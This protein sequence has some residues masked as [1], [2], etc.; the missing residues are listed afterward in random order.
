MVA[1]SLFVYAGKVGKYTN[2]C[3]C[4]ELVEPKTA[5][6][7]SESDGDRLC[8]RLATMLEKL[9]D[10]QQP[11]YLSSPIQSQNTVANSNLQASIP[12]TAANVSI[13]SN[14]NQATGTSKQ[15]PS[16]NCTE[17]SDFFDLC[18]SNENNDAEIVPTDVCEVLI[19]RIYEKQ[20]DGR[21]H[22]LVMFGEE[23]L[24]SLVD[25]GS[26]C[27]L[28]G[29]NHYENSEYLKSLPL[30]D[31]NIHFRT[32]D[33]KRH[34]CAGKL[35]VDFTAMI[36]GKKVTRTI[37]TLITSMAIPSPI[38]GVDFQNAMGIKMIQVSAID[39]DESNVECN[40]NNKP[41][42]GIVEQKHELTPDMQAELDAVLELFPF[43]NDEGPLNATSKIE[44]RIELRD[45]TPIYQ[46]PYPIT[47]RDLP[48][49]NKEATR[50]LNRGIIEPMEHGEW[51]NPVI[52]VPK[53]DGRVRLVLDGRMLNKLT[54]PD[55]ALQFDIERVLSRI[56]KAVYISTIDLNDA[57]LQL[58]LSKDSQKYTRF[59]L[60]TIGSFCFTRMVPGLT[61]APASLARLVYRMFKADEIPELLVYAD[62]FIIITETWERHL[63][64]LKLV[65]ERFKEFE[66]VVS[67]TKSYFAMKQV[68]WL[69]QV[70]N[71]DGLQIEES[72]IQAIQNYKRPQT[73]RDV[74][75]FLGVCGW[76]RRFVDNF[77]EI[78]T[79][80]TN[81]LRKTNEPIIKWTD[82]EE[83]AF[84]D[85]KNTF[86]KAPTLAGPQYDKE[87]IIDVSSSENAI[88]AVLLQFQNDEHVK[89]IA[90]MS[91]K[92]PKAQRH[93][94]PAEKDLIAVI[95]ACERW[96]IYIAGKTTTVFTNTPNVAWLNAR[97]DATGRLSRLS[98][99]IQSYD[100]K[101][102]NRPSKSKFNLADAL[103]EQAN[104]DTEVF[105]EQTLELPGDDFIN[106]SQCNNPKPVTN[107][108]NSEVQFINANP[109]PGDVINPVTIS[110]NSE[111]SE[112]AS[113]GVDAHSEANT[114]IKKSI[115]KP[116][117]GDE[118]ENVDL[119][120]SVK[121]GNNPIKRRR[122]ARRSKRTAHSEIQNTVSVVSIC[123]DLLDIGKSNKTH[124]LTSNTLCKTADFP[125]KNT[126]ESESDD[127]PQYSTALVI[128]K[129]R[130]VSEIKE[131][132]I[133]SE[134]CVSTTDGEIYLPG[135]ATESISYHYNPIRDLFTVSDDYTRKTE[136][137]STIPTFSVNNFTSTKCNW[138]WER[139]ELAISTECEKQKN[140]SEGFFVKNDLL[141]WRTSEFWHVGEHPYKVCVPSD[142]QT[143][144]M[145]QEHD[146]LHHPGQYKTYMN[147]KMKYY[148][149]NMRRVIAEYVKACEICRLCKSSNERTIVPITGQRQP[150]FNF[151]TIAIDFLGPLPKTS[152]RNVFIIVA[153]CKLSKFVWL[154]AIPSA[155]TAATI[156]FLHEEIFFRY[157]V[158]QTIICDNGSQFTSEHF[159]EFCNAF[160]V[161][162][163]YNSN[164]HPQANF[165]ESTNKTIGNSL[166]VKILAN[167]A[168]HTTWDINLYE[169]THSLNSTI[170][171]RTKISPF[172]AILGRKATINGAEFNQ[173]RVNDITD[174]DQSE[175]KARRNVISEYIVRNLNKSYRDS[176]KHYNLRTRERT[177]RV[178][179]T[180]YIKNTKL[181]NK[182]EKYM[183]K[184]A[185]KKLKAIVIE[186]LSSTMYKLKKM[187]GEVIKG[188]YHANQIYKH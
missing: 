188:T 14:E 44:H 82:I 54:V 124:E 177:F 23:A 39:T 69:G 87:F 43:N 178:G 153:S 142:F 79:P 20:Y 175:S 7:A 125:S 97:K 134:V 174:A 62:D 88:A 89:P 27:T 53:P 139:Y 22:I 66:L 95:A 165:V 150:W 132:N 16:P 21:P 51:N 1:K 164:Y 102:V 151:Q 186:K 140:E 38:L 46:K 17:L 119:L 3:S 180:V 50:L 114:E 33:C 83:N 109:T 104:D 36:Q 78:S 84:N 25:S 96:R 48:G 58:P 126:N 13:K 138:Y 110:A 172:E 187:N 92:L 111:N 183:A 112:G 28:V 32:A 118:N 63:E 26:Q 86:T 29:I 115:I 107:S 98:M 81:I 176:T 70:L 90:Y 73:V 72:K 34:K 2:K 161:T 155:T 158:P 76:L 103:S 68:R 128:H 9:I 52:V 156:A 137:V 185:P 15:D 157:S 179:E 42:L 116:S 85:L 147:I 135:Y 47:N 127:K 45:H 100:L 169:I 99:R 133:S 31:S 144:V 162:I 163:Q 106:G 101:F 37:D 40:S 75:R 55:R 166:R 61:S 71:K 57:F 152:R 19:Q 59:T 129:N 167:E 113:N 159:K 94:E 8:N 30:L 108:A 18:E 121:V 148:F 136:V 74:R 105:D 6:I 41:K 123:S 130:G 117:P 93:Y 11:I 171:T 60:P 154:R 149:P 80:L 131:K 173:L 12:Q 4:R 10:K 184:L 49:T 145:Q 170:H 182:A 65:A 5:P 77:A 91:N 56:G 168:A 64:V 24:E 146:K 67:R 35:K 122:R 181:S 120:P 141:Y 160:G 143:M